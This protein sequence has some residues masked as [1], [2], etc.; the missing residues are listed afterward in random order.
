[1]AA[2]A[3]ACAP[4]GGSSSF[5]GQFIVTS[6]SFIENVNSSSVTV[7]FYGTGG[8]G[9]QG[10]SSTQQFTQDGA[11]SLPFSQMTGST[12][13]TAALGTFYTETL[14]GLI[15]GVENW[16][17]TQATGNGTSAYSAVLNVTPAFGQV[18][19]FGAG[20]DG[21]QGI[22]NNRQIMPFAVRYGPSGNLLVADGYGNRVVMLS[23]AG[24][25]LGWIG[26]GQSGWQLGGAPAPGNGDGQFSFPGDVAW[27]TQGNLYVS[28]YVNNRVQK[29]TA[30]G[31][32]VGWIGGGS[33]GWQTGAAPAAGS[34]DAQFNSPVS[35]AVD[36]SG[37]LWVSDTSNARIQKWTTAGTYLG[38]IGGG[39]SG[40]QT[41][42]A[43]ASGTGNGQF[44]YAYGI[45]FDSS[46]NL[47]VGDCGNNRVQKW[48][49]GLSAVGWLGGG[50]NGWQTGTAPSWGVVDKYFSCPFGV[51]VASDGTLYV[52]DNGGSLQQ[53]TSA[54]TFEGRFGNGLD[55]W[56]TGQSTY[57]SGYGDKYLNE[58]DGV[59][60][61]PQG[62][63]YIADSC[64]GR[65]V[66]LNASGRYQGW[67]GAGQ[68]G[69]QMG[70]AVAILD[71]SGEPRSFSQPSSITID[72]AGNFY[73]TDQWNHVVSKWSSSGT[74]L[75]ALGNGL[76]GW[77]VSTGTASGAGDKFLDGPISSA[78][79]ASG[80]LYVSDSGNS[81]IEK[82]D[83]TGTYVGWIGGGSSGWKTG[84]AP[85]AGSG[86][87]AFNTPGAIR[88]QGN[89]LYV[90]DRANN[91]IQKWDISG[92]AGTH[93]GWLG[94]GSSGWKTG[95]APA[96]GN[97]D[98]QFNAPGGFDIDSGGD[99]YAIDIGNNRVQKWVLLTGA[100]AGWLGG[101][102]GWQ[103][104]TAPASGSGDRAFKFTGSGLYANL[105]QLALDPSSGALYVTDSGNARIQQWNAATGA[106]VGWAGRG[107]PGWSTGTPSG[108]VQ[109]A[110]L[111]GQV[112]IGVQGIAVGGDGT[113][114][115]TDLYSGKIASW[116]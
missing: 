39:A 34:G 81:R 16:F 98:A 86:D 18:S 77:N 38:W 58:P 60:I 5:N 25:F 26:G 3:G 19:W 36:G 53:W 13:Q 2:S 105:S 65:I 72:G 17:V 49:A 10:A 78:V 24:D 47:Y 57:N 29:W 90:A 103:L 37:N 75:G 115:T 52:A 110:V 20:H 9:A 56:V 61:D 87:A 114:Y 28:D 50:A 111:N 27:D 73:V 76:N 99:L 85:A 15:P 41:G 44:D 70:V 43:P 7:S 46:G 14:G 51:T 4:G 89:F 35:L 104:G 106:Y 6:Q 100:Y 30:D 54:G 82:W 91:R 1:L 79:D 68:S 62:N 32:Y 64:N 108:P 107:A 71:Y 116:K 22:S 112:S 83:S 59:A 23:T 69:L 42:T 55:G 96:A 63:F 113:V 8:S 66:V 94:G 92:G 95:A 102:D 11:S 67:F 84:A 80:N 93:V 88:V 12:Q 40:L 109:A 48:S 33:S 74:Y 31:H 97:G 101:A 45:S 21:W